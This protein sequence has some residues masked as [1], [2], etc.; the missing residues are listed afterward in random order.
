[1]LVVAVLLLISHLVFGLFSFVDA[2]PLRGPHTRPL[3]VS[4]HG[5]AEDLIVGRT[6]WA[7]RAGLLLVRRNFWS[8]GPQK[9]DVKSAVILCMCPLP[10]RCYVSASCRS[11]A[12][13]CGG[14]YG[15]DV[16]YRGIARVRA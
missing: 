12:G 13:V 11:R 10:R 14:S 15:L 2:M 16:A 6:P 3:G 8:Y 7:P 4:P 9:P 5:T 1:C